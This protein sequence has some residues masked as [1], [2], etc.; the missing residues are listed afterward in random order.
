MGNKQDKNKD[1]G[2][3]DAPQKTARTKDNKVVEGLTEEIIQNQNQLSL[4]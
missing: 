2:S 4:I 3:D 1:K